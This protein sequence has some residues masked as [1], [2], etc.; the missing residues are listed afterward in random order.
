MKEV[1]KNYDKLKNTQKSIAIIVSVLLAIISFT[2][3]YYA[4]KLIQSSKA[5]KNLKVSAVNELKDFTGMV[6]IKSIP[7]I[8]KSLS[9][10]HSHEEVLY[11]ENYEEI[12]KQV[13]SENEDVKITDENGKNIHDI[14]KNK[15]FVMKWFPHKDKKKWADFKM[16]KIEI[17]PENAEKYFELE[18]LYDKEFV[19]SK[20]K[21]LGVLETDKITIIGHLSEN[22]ISSGNP[23]IISNLSDEE[24]TKKL[25]NNCTTF[26][27]LTA[28]SIL[29]LLPAIIVLLKIF[30][31]SIS[32]I[33]ISIFSLLISSLI[34]YVLYLVL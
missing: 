11:Y 12:Y 25:N 14:V 31:K 4:N 34:F 27:L 5:V 6:K 2:N 8:E 17:Q 19:K 30:Q 3:F 15:D 13:L 9:A 16:G 23:F 7:K 24:L 26:W 29:L 22:Q 10:P 33:Y 28:L 32:N 20:K 18:T 21:T 1:R